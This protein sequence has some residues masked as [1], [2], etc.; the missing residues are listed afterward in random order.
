MSF[1][2]EPPADEH[3]ESHEGHH[4]AHHKA[5]HEGH[6]E[7]HEKAHDE[8]RHEARHEDRR[9]QR[10]DEHYAHH[11]R[12][13]WW[14]AWN[15][16]TANE[17]TSWFNGWGWSNPV[18]YEYGPTGT[19][20]SQNDEVYL[21]GDRANT[22]GRNATTATAATALAGVNPSNAAPNDEGDWLPLGSFALSRQ[23][24]KGDK[25]LQV[26]QLAVNKN[27]AIS[28]VLLD[29]AKNTSVPIQGS[30][31]RA[32]QRANFALEDQSGLV[33]ETGIYNLTRNKADVLMR[34]GSEKPRHYSLTR[35]Q[36]AP[37]NTPDLTK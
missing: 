33:A 5:H 1:G 10:H 15:R 2:H 32:T 17:L 19:L 24:G 3:H 11:E 25:P 28:G 27:G 16:P 8:A 37:A 13:P 26:V 36:S 34:Q 12:H 18:Y 20:V 23:G 6:H 31:D 14:H 30:V 35:L 7:A 29:L 21:N 4:E 22:T 9:D